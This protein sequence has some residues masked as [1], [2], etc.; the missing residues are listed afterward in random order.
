MVSYGLLK[1]LCYKAYRDNEEEQ[2]CK[3]SNSCV[4]SSRSK[5]KPLTCAL[6]G[7]PTMNSVGG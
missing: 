3:Y 4:F 6:D 5:R 7:P 2:L 1:V